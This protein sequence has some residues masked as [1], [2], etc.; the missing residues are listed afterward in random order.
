MGDSWRDAG[1]WLERGLV[2]K[3][4]CGLVG[5]EGTQELV[6]KKEVNKDVSQSLFMINIYSQME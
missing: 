3:K 6:G 4:K 2:G 1:G 5:T